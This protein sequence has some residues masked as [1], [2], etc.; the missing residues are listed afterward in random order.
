MLFG[1]ISAD[2]VAIDSVSSKGM[3][4][5]LQFSDCEN[6]MFLG[7]TKNIGSTGEPE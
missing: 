3:T 6:P 5:C 7:C 4:E 1:D 2:S